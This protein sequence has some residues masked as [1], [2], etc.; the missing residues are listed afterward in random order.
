MSVLCIFFSKKKKKELKYAVL[1]YDKC[2]FCN[3]ILR[4]MFDC[5]AVKLK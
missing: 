3:E 5:E 1:F 4:N 2:Y